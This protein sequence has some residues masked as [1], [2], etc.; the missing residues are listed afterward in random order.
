[1]AEVFFYNWERRPV[2]IWSN[3]S[4]IE[5]RNVDVASFDATLSK[6][7]FEASVM[8][9]TNLNDLIGFKENLNKL[10]QQKCLVVVFV[11]SD[12]RIRIEFRREKS[13]RIYQSYLIKEEG[14]NNNLA[15]SD[16][17]D[18]TFLPELIGEINTI[19]MN[20]GI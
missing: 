17:F 9:R 4:R 15:V 11:S 14:T 13:G 5:H 6:S 2:M 1:M 7:I 10:F 20:K 19:L 8:I 16:Y 3:F 18:Q 12:E